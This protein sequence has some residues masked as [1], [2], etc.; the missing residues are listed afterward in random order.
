[1]ESRTLRRIWLAGIWL[2]FP[3]PFL[4][5]AD[6]WVPA[7][8]YLLLAGVAGVVALLEGSAGP[9]RLLVLLFAVWGVGTSLLCWLLAWLMEKLMNLL[10]NRLAIAITLGVLG[11]GL[12]WAIFFEPY[13]TPFGRALRGGLLQVLS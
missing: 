12:F 11:S 6:A 3:W 10:P 2:L 4:I 9:V 8:R 7:V 13:R 1:M 5:L